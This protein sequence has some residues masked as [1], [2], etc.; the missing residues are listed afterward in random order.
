LPIGLIE[1]SIRLHG[2]HSL[3]DKRSVIKPILK[4]LRDMFNCAA[5]ESDMHDFHE[6]TVISVVT[7]NTNAIELEKT[8][9]NIA[10]AVERIGGYD[11]TVSNKEVIG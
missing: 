3:K 7:I 11:V 4:K 6:M 5:I 2:V 8:M 1:L 10:K 9:T